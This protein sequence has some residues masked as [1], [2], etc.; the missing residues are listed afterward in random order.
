M[1]RRDFGKT[2]GM[3]AATAV[4][5]PKILADSA[6][7]N[8]NERIEL[9]EYG[10]TPE[11]IY[12]IIRMRHGKLR[13]CDIFNEVKKEF[14]QEVEDGADKKGWHYGDPCKVMGRIGST[15]ENTWGPMY[16][17]T[18]TDLSDINYVAFVRQAI[19]NKHTNELKYV[20]AWSPVQADSVEPGQTITAK[21]W[22]RID[23]SDEEVKRIARE[24]FSIFQE[25][26]IEYHNREA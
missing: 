8:L 26:V 10:Y 12:A 1:N 11:Q 9:E 5:A 13:I 15:C 19:R 16:F 7:E 17:H 2:A 4:V 23:T 21:E 22:I 18:H 3:V 20:A 6:K 24:T 14:P 25:L